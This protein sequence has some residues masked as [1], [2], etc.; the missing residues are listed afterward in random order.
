MTRTGEIESGCGE[1]RAKSGKKSGIILFVHLVRFVH[2]YE[3]TN[4]TNG[5]RSK[6]TIISPTGV[7]L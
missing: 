5:T 3:R 6:R 2:P 4:R 1:Q 7:H